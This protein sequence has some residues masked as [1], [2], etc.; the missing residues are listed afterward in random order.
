MEVSVRSFVPP[1]GTMRINPNG[2]QHEKKR[3]GKIITD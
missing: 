3:F 1:E 2:D